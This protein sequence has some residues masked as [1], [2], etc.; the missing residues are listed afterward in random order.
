MLD[1]R[2]KTDKKYIGIAPRTKEPNIL[3]R[4]PYASS[5]SQ[6]IDFMLLKKINFYKCQH[7]EME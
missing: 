6:A 3:N 5:N 1:K 4:D 2:V 7:C